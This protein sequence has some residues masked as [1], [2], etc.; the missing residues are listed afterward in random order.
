M[1]APDDR[2]VLVDS[3]RLPFAIQRLLEDVVVHE[4]V[5]LHSGGRALPGLGEERGEILDAALRDDD[6]AAAPFAPPAPAQE[7]IEREHQDPEDDE[8]EQRLP[9][10]ALQSQG[11][12]QIGEV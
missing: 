6:L 2:V 10:E 12:Y 4:A 7:S 3:Q 1:K 5:Q 9:Q 8:V 11:V